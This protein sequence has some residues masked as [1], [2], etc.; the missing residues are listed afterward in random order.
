MVLTLQPK[1]SGGV[2]LIPGR[3]PPLKGHDK[4]CGLN[5]HLVATVLYF[6]DL[7]VWC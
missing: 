7:S 5:K 4:G 3:A 2:G 1:Q 6:Y